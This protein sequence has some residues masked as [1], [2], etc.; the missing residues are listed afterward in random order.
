MFF[1]VDVETS[2]LTPWSGGQLLSLG[3][4]P[5]T[6]DGEVMKDPENHLYLKLT[7]TAKP[8]LYIHSEDRTDTDKFWVNVFNSYDG[9][10][11]HNPYTEAFVDTFR[12]TL[13]IA[14]LIIRDYVDK[15]EPDKSKRFIAANPVAFD[16]MWMEYLYG[17]RYDNYWPFHYR[18]LCLRS[19]RYGLEP[20][21]EYGSRKGAQKSEVEHHALFDARG[22]A[23]DLAYLINLK[24]D[25]HGQSIRSFGS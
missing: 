4:V 21:V 12:H 5:V 10:V 23:A 25:I 6:E 8:P 15:I 2:G 24:K 7:H 9:S 1:V 11:E 20:E 22:E 19:L 3:I 17:D 18:C 14:Q 16:K 13:P